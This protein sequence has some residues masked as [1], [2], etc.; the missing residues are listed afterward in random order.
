MNILVLDVAAS[1]SGAL[2]VL[3]QYHQLLQQDTENHYFF[4]V[5]VPQLESGG[6]LTVCRFPWVKKSWLHR[7]WFEWFWVPKLVK[8]YHI[9]RVFSLENLILRNL[10][11]EKWIYLHHPIPFVDVSFS[12]IGDPLMWTYQNVVGKLMIASLRHADHV[13]VQTNWMKA[14]CIAKGH[15]AEA[16]IEVR[17]PEI[18][19]EDVVVCTDRAAASTK[20]LYP[21][22]ALKYKNHRLVLQALQQMKDRETIG[23][24]EVE[25]TLDGQENP[26][27]RE[28]LSDVQTHDLPVSFIGRLPREA[29]ME[30]Y[31]RRTLVFPSYIETFGLPLLEARRSNALVIASDC[32]FSREI[33]AGYDGAA[34]FDPFDATALRTLLER[35]VQNRGL[36]TA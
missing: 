36:T 34:F 20:L 14:A 8:Q 2:T 22:T 30:R 23:D 17:Q 1:E 13:I 24:L 21:A 26:L 33:L 11:C 18:P 35:L 28:L 10:P 19:A 9:S 32:P 7:L 29:L 15:L 27:A 16:A 5:S 6:N 3:R 25:F 31:A 4:C 12:L